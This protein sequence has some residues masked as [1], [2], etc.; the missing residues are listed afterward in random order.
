MESQNTL[1]EKLYKR[2]NTSQRLAVDT[3]EGAVMV[4]A[5][6]GTGKTQTLILR[7]ANILRRTQ[8]NPENILA[9]TFTD[10]AAYEMRDRLVEVI[11]TAGYRVQI[12]TFHEFCNSVIQ[13][14]PE[15]FPHLLNASPINELEQIQMGE[16]ILTDNS[17]TYLRPMNAPLYYLKSTLETIG[18]LKK[19][20]VSTSAFEKG[21]SKQLQEFRKITDLYHTKGKFKGKLK[22]KYRTLLNQ[23]QRNK[24][25][26]LMYKVYQR[27]L[28]KQLKYDFHDM[29]LEVMRAFSRNTELL[30]QIQEIYQ[31][32]LVDEQQDTN[33]AQNQ[34]LHLLCGYYK[35]PNLFV[36]GDEKQAIYRFQGASL[37]NFLYFQNQYPDAVCIYLEKNYRSTQSLLDG[38]QSLIQRSP[39]ES[40][41]RRDKLIAQNPSKYN[42]I[43]CA[44]LHDYYAE[45][46]YV[47][48]S[49][50]QKLK[51]GIPPKEIAVLVRNNKDILPVMQIF[52]KHNILCSSDSNNNVFDDWDIQKIL[53]IFRCIHMFGEDQPL[54]KV[55]HIN[56]FHIDPF[57]IYQLLLEV[58]RTGLSLWTICLE[59]RCTKHIRLQNS[60]SLKNLF[61]LLKNWKTRVENESFDTVFVD[62]LNRSGLLVQIL[63]RTDALEALRKLTTLFYHIKQALSKNHEYSLSQFIEYCDLL[64]FHQIGLRTGYSSIFIN[65]VRIMTAHRAKGMEFDYVYIVNAFDGHWGNKRNSRNFFCIPWKNLSVVF[66][67]RTRNDE[68]E[69]ERRLF[70]VALT[71]ARREVLISYSCRSLEGADQVESQFVTEIDSSLKQKVDTRVFESEFSQHPERVMQSSLVVRSKKDLSLHDRAFVPDLFLFRGLSV[72]GL[73]NYLECPWKYFFRNLLQ[74]P[75][76]KNLSMIF[77]SAVH[78]AVDAYLT[79]LTGDKITLKGIMQTYKNS[80]LKQPLNKDEFEKLQLKGKSILSK[81]YE[82]VMKGWNKTCSGEIIVKGIR[83]GNGVFL[84][85][86]IDMVKQLDNRGSVAVYDFKTGTPKSRSFIQGATGSKIGNYKRQLIFYKLL[87]ERFK[88][89]KQPVTVVQGIIQFVEPTQNGTFRSEAFEISRQEVVELEHTITQ[90]SEEIKSLSFW[91]RFCENKGC[92]YCSMRRFLNSDGD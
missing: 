46:Y 6:P 50:Q 89:T 54:M 49:V 59:E 28:K 48:E 51:Q 66:D 81:F 80:L 38:A 25:L 52:Q 21:V 72:S 57:D 4:I 83:F 74:V 47:A 17:F 10:S 71:R 22:G 79:S 20:G 24:E 56:C 85:G 32:F 78:S 40:L 36:V 37:E 23:I 75:D 64:T 9:L 8:A 2:L 3:V 86:K 42:S 30:L 73:N 35:N 12:T 16:K 53:A 60:S 19:E 77:G 63:K 62:V 15:F 45:Y 70:Y 34:I 67:T 7:I 13:K 90:I 5:G 84:N 88:E 58:S 26:V 65:S 18:Q 55:M 41:L 91:D 31:Y 76:V 14:N 87:L 69:D 27:E 11:G 43:L 39:L 82:Q 61:H 33:S 92:F 68:N 1:F 29:L 44:Q